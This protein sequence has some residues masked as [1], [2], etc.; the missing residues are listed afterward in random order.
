[1]RLALIAVGRMKAGPERELADRYAKR[2][3]S[4]ARPLGLDWR[5]VTELSEARDAGA[6]ARREGEAEA[7]LSRVEPGTRLVALD[8]RGKEP[9]SP[10][11][12]DL[13]ARHRDDGVPSLALAIGGPDGHGRSLLDRADATIAFGRLTWPHQIV[14][15]LALEQLYRAATIL[16]GHPYH[17]S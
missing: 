1:M 9:T 7:I 4:T 14:R 10:E 2:L 3:A 6:D 8:E 15:V 11:F 17:R 16:A 12:A 13:L 5:G